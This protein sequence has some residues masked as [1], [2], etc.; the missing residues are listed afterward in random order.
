MMSHAQV[1]EAHDAESA[2]HTDSALA[3]QKQIDTSGGSTGAAFR[4]I[5][6]NGRQHIDSEARAAGAT[7]HWRSAFV[8][9]GMIVQGFG[10]WWRRRR[11]R[12]LLSDLTNEQIKDIGMEGHPARLRREAEQERYRYLDLLR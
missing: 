2:R 1:Q 12:L 5:D 6:S 7:T 4:L 9:A 11:S 10:V 3:V 8:L